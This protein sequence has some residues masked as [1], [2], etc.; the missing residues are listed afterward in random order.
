VL[1]ERLTLTDFG[2]CSG[3]LSV[4]YAMQDWVALAQKRA[5]ISMIS[6]GSCKLSYIRCHREARRASL[7]S[8]GIE[9]NC[10]LYG[11]VRAAIRLAEGGALLHPSHSRST[12]SEFMKRCS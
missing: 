7:L 4:Q 10:S 6:I 2:S 12:K 5:A 8:R 1:Q 3:T 11:V 9:S